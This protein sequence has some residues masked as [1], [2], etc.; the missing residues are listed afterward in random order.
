MKM[1]YYLFGL[2]TMSVLVFG[3]GAPVIAQ[4][5]MPGED[6]LSGGP[7][8]GTYYFDFDMNLI[9]SWWQPPT[10]QI[11]VNLVNTD[12]YYNVT[13]MKSPLDE[14]FNAGFITGGGE[15]GPMFAIEGTLEGS[16]L[17]VKI[18]NDQTT[19]FGRLLDLQGALIL[20]NNITLSWM[21]P[22]GEEP[23]PDEALAMELLPDNFTIPAGSGIPPLPLTKMA[24][25]FSQFSSLNDWFWDFGYEGGLPFFVPAIFYI[26]N[27]NDAESYW[28]Y[29][30]S[31][32]EIFPFTI[33]D[34]PWTN[35]TTNNSSYLDGTGF[36]LSIG[37]DAY[38]DTFD[39]GNLAIDADWNNDGYL[40]NFTFDMF[41][42]NSQNGILEPEEEYYIR[43]ELEE[44]QRDPIP[45]S[46]GD[47][48][49]YIIEIDLTASVD[50]END[51]LEAI[52]NDLLTAITESINEL[53]GYPLLNYTV[54]SM[55]GLFFTLDGYLLDLP[56]FI[57]DR[58][59]F[60]GTEPMAGFGSQELP[61]P[62]PPV[63]DYYQP[64]MEYYDDRGYHPNVLNLYD[65]SVYFNSTLFYEL[66]DGW[67]WWDEYGWE[68]HDPLYAYDNRTLEIPDNPGIVN[69]L[70]FN[71]TD[72]WNNYDHELSFIENLENR[73]AEGLAV[74]E[75]PVTYV[76][77]EDNYYDE[78]EDRW[79]NYTW[80]DAVIFAN[81]TEPFNE[82][83]P[84][85]LVMEI[86]EMPNT[87][88]T[89]YLGMN[90]LMKMMM[91]GPKGPEYAGLGSQDEE[92]M[93]LFNLPFDFDP[94]RS[95]PFPARTP[96]WDVVGTL[97]VFMESFVDA[98]SDI[99]TDPAFAAMVSTMTG[100]DPGDYVS[101]NAVD[102][103][104]NWD[105]N[106][107]NAGIS[108]YL[109]LDET[110]VDNDTGKEAIVTFD[111]SIV[112]YGETYWDI[113]GYFD[114]V[115][116]SYSLTLGI[117]VEDWPEP[118][119]T[120]TVPTNETDTNTTSPPDTSI[121]PELTP[122]FETIA[123]LSGLIAVPVFFKKRR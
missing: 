83:Q 25:N 71:D 59:P 32:D 6:P 114:S 46:V 108:A 53:N 60:F 112:S 98:I 42:D 13:D 85:V 5:P 41:I 22:E 65:S 119:T 123:V 100:D 84:Y 28:A 62:L 54:T 88:Y 3:L 99:I 18:V 111:V 17:V 121:P 66:F 30:A 49:E 64:M 44:I 39:F 1:R 91:G 94:R 11:P 38:N 77:E 90:P 89:T 87:N 75:G 107:T 70:V 80:K 26:D 74:Y 79:Y 113:D 43:F 122:G 40:A 61:P 93:M 23:S 4:E 16:D 55:D 118:P 101:I 57:S 69:A 104:F 109:M 31:V 45:I 63:E 73:I 106:T 10:P 21:L 72:W 36:H 68:H 120:T 50:L 115:G 37:F 103:D 47:G 24:T 105:L 116:S 67:T 92:P 76:D 19:G 15:G 96:D 58:L 110:V 97:P 34:D 7:F 35:Y 102:V 51:T 33:E 14:Y 117:S 29:E 9:N 78:W 82:D 56:R 20:G 27:L 52:L 2:L 86:S 8:P 48:G 95:I 12:L 81:E